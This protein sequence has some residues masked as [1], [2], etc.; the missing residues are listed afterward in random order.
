MQRGQI[1]HPERGGGAVLMAC[2]LRSLR[3]VWT[4]IRARRQSYVSH[5]SLHAPA[6][7][8]VKVGWLG[9]WVHWWTPAWHAGRGPYVSIGLGVVGIYRGY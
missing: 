2:Y 3:S 5:L 6:S 4:G 8:K 1:H 7:W 9:F